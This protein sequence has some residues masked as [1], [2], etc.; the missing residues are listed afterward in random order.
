MTAKS[1]SHQTRQHLPAVHHEDGS[2]L[3]LGVWLLDVARCCGNLCSEHDEYDE[4][5][6]DFGVP[7][8]QPEPNFL[9][10]PHAEG[11]ALRIRMFSEEQ[12]CWGEKPDA[13][14]VGACNPGKAVVSDFE[15][16]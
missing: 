10:K 7:N 12:L 5:P 6:L 15:Y 3:S 4:K 9:P 11:L 1:D 14:C 16:L 2:P 8:C 13:W